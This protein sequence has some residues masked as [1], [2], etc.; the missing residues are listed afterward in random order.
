MARA[1]CIEHSV[2]LGGKGDASLDGGSATIAGVTV[3]GL[4]TTLAYNS[5]GQLATVT[6]PAGRSN[7]EPTI[8]SGALTRRQ[9]RT[10]CIQLKRRGTSA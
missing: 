4:V 10:L 6:D 7:N 9:S 8:C 2:S 1:F 3:A 5:A